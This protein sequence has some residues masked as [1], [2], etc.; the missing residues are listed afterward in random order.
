[1]KDDFVT[2]HQPKGERSVNRITIWHNPR[3]SKSRASLALLEE[4]GVTPEQVL[5]LETPPSKDQ[6]TQ[7][8]S[9]LN[10]KAIDIMRTTEPTFKT[11]NLSK[12]LDELVLIEAM[13]NN[14]IL[15]ER[16]I[17][18]AGNQ[19]VIGRPPENVLRLL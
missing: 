1:M 19:A 9:Y 16:P 11:L 17:V 8:L 6:I 10:A 3:C 18:I 15:I 7:T 5:Y 13:V 4:N 2:R 12:D 14:P